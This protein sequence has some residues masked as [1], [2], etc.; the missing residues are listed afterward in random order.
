VLSVKGC[1]CG[2]KSDNDFQG[3]QGVQCPSHHSLSEEPCVRNHAESGHERVEYRSPMLE[4]WAESDVI[5]QLVYAADKYQLT[6]LFEFLDQVVGVVCTKETAGKL[7]NLAK[8]LSMKK[9]E[10]DLFEFMKKHAS[11]FEEMVSF[12]SDGTTTDV[13]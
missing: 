5:I 12:S 6:D 2:D 3:Q 1:S 4:D 10:K 9:A 11:S 7:L 8:K 13:I